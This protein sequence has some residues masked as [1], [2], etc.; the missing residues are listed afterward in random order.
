MRKHDQR[1]NIS[2][3]EMKIGEDK[4]YELIYIRYDERNV[5]KFPLV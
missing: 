3:G 5:Y 1:L 4:N 2:D